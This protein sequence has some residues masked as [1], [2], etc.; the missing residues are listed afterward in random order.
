M[1]ASERTAYF[2]ARCHPVVVHFPIA[3]LLLGLLAEILH[4]TR[5][6]DS[7]AQTARFCAILGAVAAV[8]ATV[9]GLMLE[10]HYDGNLHDLLERHEMLGIATAV[11]A[12]FAAGF[13]VA[14]DPARR[15]WRF[16]LAR[17]LLLAACLTV[18]LA[19]HLGGSL[20]YGPDYFSW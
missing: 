9:L 7:Y 19:G 6:R 13:Y 14:A 3:I 8:V 1:S 16:W 15:D 18:G 2:V 4:L 20:V 11:L 10:E 12:V 17:I 5:R